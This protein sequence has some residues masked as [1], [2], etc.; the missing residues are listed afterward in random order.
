MMPL[1]PVRSVERCAGTQRA[2]V[3]GLS[4]SLHDGTSGVATMSLVDL[5]AAALLLGERRHPGCVCLLF[6]SQHCLLASALDHY[7]RRTS[8][9]V[10][11]DQILCGFAA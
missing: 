3:G 7:I 4:V 5:S 8:V 10:P 9:A 2:G 1:V 11:V 6:C